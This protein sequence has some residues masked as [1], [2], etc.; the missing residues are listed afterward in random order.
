LKINPYLTDYSSKRK[1]ELESLLKNMNNHA[2]L[3]KDKETEVDSKL[4]KLYEGFDNEW[5]ERNEKME[6]L[7]K[8]IENH[9]SAEIVRHIK[10][11][12]INKITKHKKDL[13]EYLI[14]KNTELTEC[15]DDLCKQKVQK[16]ID[17]IKKTNDNMDQIISFFQ[18]KM[19]EYMDKED[20]KI[21]EGVDDSEDDEV[22]KSDKKNQNESIKA[23]DEFLG[24]SDNSNIK[25]INVEDNLESLISND[26][27]DETIGLEEDYEGVY[28]RPS[29]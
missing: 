27:T 9:N 18:K 3:L 2:Q 5:A 4:K 28:P 22:M 6:E 15:K 11:H 26:F 19:E 23:M 7:E 29:N 10:E 20:I 16:I 21:M 25:P 24:D 14:S 12:W 13:S 17:W 1:A 8:H